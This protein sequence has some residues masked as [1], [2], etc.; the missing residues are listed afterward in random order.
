[1]SEV[2]Y[3]KH[4]KVFY[5][6]LI[7]DQNF[8]PTHISLYMALFQLW[9][10][11]RFQSPFY[12]NRNEV[13]TMAKIGSKT[14]YHKCIRD[15]NKWKYIKYKPSQNPFKSSEVHLFNFWTSSGQVVGQDVGQVVGQPVGQALVSYY[16]H[17]KHIKHN[18]QYKQENKNFDFLK[19][20][21]DKD[22][23]Q[24]L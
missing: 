14:T 19:V 21:N 17:N 24:P 20:E 11:N 12:V 16:K 1:M 23:N 6:K 10:I 8:N 22:Y 7:D 4:L 13:M 15:L 2:N 3:I 5:D 9:N 18:K